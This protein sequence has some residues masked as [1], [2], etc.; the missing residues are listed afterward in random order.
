MGEIKAHTRFRKDKVYG[1]FLL[2]AYGGFVSCPYRQTLRL[3]YVG[4]QGVEINNGGIY[5]KPN[6]N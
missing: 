6:D 3:F 4:G 2:L 1:P 5:G